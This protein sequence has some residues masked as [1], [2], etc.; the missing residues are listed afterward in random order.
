MQSSNKPN[1]DFAKKVIVSSL[2]TGSY[3]VTAAWADVDNGFSITIPTT[4]LYRLTCQCIAEVAHTTNTINSVELVLANNG[5]DIPGSW[6][7]TYKNITTA[8]SVAQTNTLEAPIQMLS[9]GDVIKLRAR[10]T[11]TDT[12][13]ILFGVTVGG[14]IQAELLSQ[15][16]NTIPSITDWQ[17][18][19]MNIGAVTT[20]PT[21]GTIVVDNAQ[22]RR[23]GSNMEIMYTYLQSVA[24]ASGSGIYLF[25]IPAGY[26]IDT[27][28]MATCL[29]TGN[30]GVGAA[31]SGNAYNG[32]NHYPIVSLVYDSGNICLRYDSTSSLISNAAMGL[33]SAANLTISFK[34]SVPIVGW[35]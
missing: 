30:Y 19:V 12:C 24:G 26:T 5:V 33:G 23:V 34:A 27:A 1:I 16:V 6:G 18:Y 7:R 14:F 31:G 22:W 3:T 9:A 4:G 20:A 8:F 2:Q 21:K 10:K 32:T 35:S 29:G 13:S 15:Y 17:S 25:P 28:L 11:N